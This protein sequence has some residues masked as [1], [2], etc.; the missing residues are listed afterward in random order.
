MEKAIKVSFVGILVNLLLS[1]FKLLAGT[2]GKSGAMV[3]DSIHSASDVISSLIVIIGIKF[4]HKDADKEHQYGHERIECIA[5]IVLSAILAVVGLE[6]GINVIFGNYSDLQVPTLIALIAALVS[7]ITKEIMFQYTKIVAKKIHSDALMADAWHHRSDAL[8][9]VG[10]LI[11]IGGAMLG[12]PILDPIASV[13]I[14][15]LIIKATI[16]IFL[17]AVSKLIDK[18]CDSDTINKMEQSAM[19]VEG[20][21][22]I[23]DIRTR[24]FGN[25]IYVDIEICA[26]G[27]LTL[28]DAHSIAENVHHKIENDFTDVKHCMVHINPINKLKDTKKNPYN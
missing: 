20:V 18:S 26:D 7:I 2:I 9:S 23:D 12:L 25:R 15:I 8:S 11:G 10:S 3:S 1:I 4:A 5:S 24:L 19:E 14:S 22:N 16:E 28:N 13:A 6:I 27:S 17:D 21:E